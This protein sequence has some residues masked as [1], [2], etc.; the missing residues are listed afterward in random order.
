MLLLSVTRDEEGKT[1]SINIRTD[2]ALFLE[3][4]QIQ[5]RVYAHTLLERFFIA[6]SLTYWQ[7][8]LK[9]AGYEFETVDRNIVVHVPKIKRL[10][11]V[12]AFAYFDYEI[13]KSSKRITL[14]QKHIKKVIADATEHNRRIIV[15]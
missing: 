2:D 7:T 8:S 14:A 13:N 11:S 15:T 3:F 10:D 1:G 5:K 4:D 6:G 9:A 12:F